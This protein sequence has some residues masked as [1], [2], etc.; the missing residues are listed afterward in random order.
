M[1]ALTTLI[2]YVEED[3]GVLSRVCYFRWFARCVS[4]REAKTAE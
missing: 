2:L 3:A 1:A 4:I